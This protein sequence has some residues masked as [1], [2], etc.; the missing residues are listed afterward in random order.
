MAYNP[1]VTNHAGELLG[2]GISSMGRSIG[3]ALKEN[4]K[5]ASVM[6]RGWDLMKENNL[7]PADSTPDDFSNRRKAKMFD[8]VMGATALMGNLARNSYYAA[9]AD[10]AARPGR[11]W[12][13]TAV[14][15]N[16][17]GAPDGVMTSPNSYQPYKRE[18]DGSSA[19]PWRE[20]MPPMVLLDEGVAGVVDPSKRAYKPVVVRSQKVFGMNPQTGTYEERMV[21]N[22]DISRLKSYR[23][24]AAPLSGSGGPS[25]AARAMGV[26]MRTGMMGGPSRVDLQ[27]LVASRGRP[28]VTPDAAAMMGGALGT[29][30]SREAS[31]YEMPV[32]DLQ[33]Q[34]T[35]TVQGFDAA[36][37][38]RRF[39]EANPD[40]SAAEAEA[41]ARRRGYIR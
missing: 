3:D 24:A 36:G 17:D 22:M 12:R 8:G 32:E 7:V 6:D 33:V 28:G 26:G 2:R 16:G 38:V 14:D 9:R 19:Y 20:G 41:E 13:P 29:P 23:D 40:L 15:V 35:S 21:P 39:M 10:E 5:K 30:V 18:A 4:R 1:S 27:N 34:G 25:P 11:P 31:P 37:V